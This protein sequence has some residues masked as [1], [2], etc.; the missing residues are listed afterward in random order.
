[1][2][3]GPEPRSVH[4]NET[5]RARAEFS[6]RKHLRAGLRML[7][8]LHG[9]YWGQP[10]PVRAGSTCQLHNNPGAPDVIAIDDSS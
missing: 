1:M 2:L 4:R 10:V 6:Q 3:G 7:I 8:G 9:V 5:R